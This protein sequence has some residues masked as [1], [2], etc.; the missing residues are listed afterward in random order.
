MK[1]GYLIG[2]IV[3][4]LA[5]ALAG[6]VC[7]RNFNLAQASSNWVKTSGKI[8]RSDL[9]DFSVGRKENFKALVEYSYDVG[10][11]IHR[12]T[13]IRFADTTGSAAEKQRAIVAQYPVNST[14]DVYYDPHHPGEAVLETGGGARA[15]ALMLPPLI[16]AGIGMTLLVYGR[17]KAL[18]RF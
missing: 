8:V 6:W 14:V 11:I 4:L 5:S 1:K 7:L 15:Y 2:G 13:R 3:F 10:G 18:E 12:G 16:L 17:R 9:Q